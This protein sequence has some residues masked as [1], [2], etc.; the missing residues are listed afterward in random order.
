MIR[1][2]FSL[3]LSLGT[4]L[5]LIWGGGAYTPVQ[6][7]FTGSPAE[8]GSAALQVTAVAAGFEHT[9]VLISGG[10]VE[11]WG[12]NR[13]GQLGAAAQTIHPFPLV[14]SLV[15]GT[16]T[17]IAAGAYH[18]CALLSNGTVQCWGLNSKGQLGNTTPQNSSSAPVA[19]SGLSNV[20]AISAGYDYTC[21]IIGT[22]PSSTVD[23][24]GNNQYG[25]LGN[26][27]TVNSI[28]PV[29][30]AGLSGAV[31]LTGSFDHTCALDS[32]GSVFCW[33]RNFYGQIGN[34][35]SGPSAVQ[36]T[37]AGL[38]ISQLPGGTTFKAVAAGAQHTCAVTTGGSVYCWG[39]G[40]LG[41]MGN[42]AST[43]INV[44][45]TTANAVSGLTT[46][47]AISAGGYS[48]TGHTCALTA[49]KAVVCWG[50]N[51]YGQLG[52]G[53]AG[54]TSNV[55][56]GSISSG[57]S[58]LTVGVNH[59]CALLSDHSVQCWGSDSSGQLGDGVNS[60]STTP[61]S[62]SGLDGNVTL[63]A[64]GDR[65]TCALDNG[66]VYCW[67]NN[68]DNQLGDGTSLNRP[69]PTLVTGLTGT[70]TGLDSG[71]SQ[72]CAIVDGGV[73]CWGDGAVTP[74]AVIPPHSGVTSLSETNLHACAVVG[75]G[76]VCWGDDT[77]GQLGDGNTTGTRAT[78]APV[79]SLTSGVKAV[80]TGQ[81]FSCAVLNN[82]T[83]SCWGDDTNG[84]LGNDAANPSPFATPQVVSGLTG[85][86]SIAAGQDHACALL[87]SGAV[88]CWGNNQQGQLGD[89]TQTQHAAPAVVPSLTSGVTQ[90][91]AG[92]YHTCALL[93]GNVQCWGFNSFGQLGNGAMVLSKVPVSAINLSIGVLAVSA[94]GVNYDEEQTCT[95]TNLHRLMCWGGDEYGQL[96]DNLPILRASPVHVVGLVDGPEVGV[97]YVT[98]QAGSYF[99]LAAANFPASAPLT[100]IVNGQEVGSV[101]ATGDGYAIFHFHPSPD[102][103]G[104]VSVI[105]SAGA[106]ASVTINL[107]QN[108]AS[109]AQEG[110]GPIY[111]S[112]PLLLYLPRIAQ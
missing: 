95:I 13:Y 67:G 83:V 46:A 62:V 52:N 21:A 112:S 29:Q 82:G 51:A 59:T 104:A 39:D 3:L 93:A 24:W 22:G 33:G 11:C 79:I 44:R 100:V 43:S 73:S 49:S 109:R 71:M 105:V 41:Q 94:G 56:V 20:S 48:D 102:L 18:T 40:S 77:H 66:Q 64:T 57:V 87:N 54:G 7:S 5:A 8:S 16:V 31:Q 35:S 38:D 80:A 47:A 84:Q 6:A 98:G 53:S 70:V 45:P 101:A 110:S 85:V 10:V 25:Q 30:A 90:I 89:G 34:G 97:N 55:P 32:N 78:P 12:S 37:P 106:G 92:G 96:G 75:G 42:G 72:T 61:V 15:G 23:C 2:I 99:R 26:T 28:F 69:A 63:V 36:L 76:A 58:A 91:S 4:S 50:S 107:T 88:E 27:S 86:A 65:N 19:V 103:T 17:Q 60:I 68:R 14:V 1:K 111:G 81:W 108:G 74:A 9:C